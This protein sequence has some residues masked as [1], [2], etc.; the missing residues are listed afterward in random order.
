MDNGFSVMYINAPTDGSS[1]RRLDSFEEN[2][3]LNHATKASHGRSVRN[4]RRQQRRNRT[5][6]MLSVLAMGTACIML[7]VMVMGLVRLGT[8][9]SDADRMESYVS[10]LQEE[11]DQLR[12]QYR[13]GYDLDQ[14]REEAKDMG[15]VPVDQL[16]QI[17][18]HA[19]NVEQ[20]PAYTIWERMGMFLA[21]LFA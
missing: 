10:A 20:Q 18:I 7:V 21:G 17:T 15:L 12:A 19:E 11:N 13:E 2:V 1:R 8:I 14:I 5:A 6:D 9:N 16:K 3:Q 4:A